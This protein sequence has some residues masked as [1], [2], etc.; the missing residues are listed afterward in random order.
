[1]HEIF[2]AE[3]FSTISIFYG[4][5]NQELGNKIERIPSALK[6]SLSHET[7]LSMQLTTSQRIG[8]LRESSIAIRYCDKL[9]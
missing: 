1:M 2:V 4:Y 6:K 7:A 5:M 8:T 9:N 3:V